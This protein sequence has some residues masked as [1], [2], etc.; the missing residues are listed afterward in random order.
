VSRR[1]HASGVRLQV[2]LKGGGPFSI[3]ERRGRP[4]PPGT[5]LGRMRALAGIVATKP[6]LKIVG[7]S[8]V[9]PLWIR[10]AL[11]DVDVRVALHLACPGI[12]RSGM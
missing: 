12:V 8:G 6:V 7:Q 3:L 5:V 1:K 10:D 2:V 9:V 11:K 4:N